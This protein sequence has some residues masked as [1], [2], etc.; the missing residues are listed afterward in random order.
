MPFHD[1][2]NAQETTQHYRFAPLFKTE[3]PGMNR[4]AEKRTMV[5]CHVARPDL[6]RPKPYHPF[7][8]T[9]KYRQHTEQ[10]RNV[11]A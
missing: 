7:D 9:A 11:T 10:V 6:L 8:A 5:T 2:Q 4:R 1:Y 3:A